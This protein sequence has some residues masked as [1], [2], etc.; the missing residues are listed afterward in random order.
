MEYIEEKNKYDFIIK[1]IKELIHN[2]NMKRKS[3]IYILDISK[4]VNTLMSEIDLNKFT[5]LEI[6]IM[7]LKKSIISDDYLKLNDYNN[8]INYLD[9][10]IIMLQKV[11]FEKTINKLIIKKCLKEKIRHE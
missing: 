2:Y 8:Y 7:G 10:K 5:F 1:L 6:V 9:N 4:N 11:I 3:I